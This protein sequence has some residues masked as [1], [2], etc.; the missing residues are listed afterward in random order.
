M[1]RIRS[2]AFDTLHGS[3]NARDRYPKPR[4]GV[5]DAEQSADEVWLFDHSLHGT[6]ALSLD[7]IRT[8]H[9][10]TN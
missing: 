3:P 5:A 1:N 8:I 2:L 9:Q 4:G 10:S 7:Q 6:D